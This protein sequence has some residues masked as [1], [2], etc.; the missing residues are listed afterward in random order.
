[1]AGHSRTYFLPPRIGEGIAKQQQF[2]TF[3][4]NFHREGEENDFQ[5]IIA[6]SSAGAYDNA[7]ALWRDCRNPPCCTTAA[8]QHVSDLEKASR[9]SH[10]GIDGFCGTSPTPVVQSR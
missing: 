4:G 3:A 6:L 2:G 5:N 10:L 9:K 8:G 1:L 7:G